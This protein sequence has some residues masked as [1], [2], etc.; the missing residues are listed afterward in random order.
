M[1]KRSGLPV[2]RLF[3]SN[4]VGLVNESSATWRSIEGVAQQLSKKLAGGHRQRAVEALHA[5]DEPA[6]F[7]EP[8]AQEFSN[9][10]F[11]LVDTIVE[12]YMV[13]G[14]VPPERVAALR[15]VIDEHHEAILAPAKEDNWEAECRVALQKITEALADAERLEMGFCEATEV[16]SGFEGVMN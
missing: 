5:T 4:L 3:L 6:V 12:N 1:S 7:V 10:E 9:L 11:F 16:Y 13:G 15:S 14:Y 2:K 8:L